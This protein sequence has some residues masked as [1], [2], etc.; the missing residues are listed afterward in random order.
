M[1]AKLIAR[2]FERARATGVDLLVLVA[3]A[4][5]CNAKRGDNLAWPSLAVLAERV[6]LTVSGLC[7][8]LKRLEAIGDIKRNRSTGGRNRRSRYL[9]CLGNSELQDTVSTVQNSEPTDSV[10]DQDSD[11]KTVSH[12]KP[13][14]TGNGVRTGN[15]TVSVR[16][17]AINKNRTRKRES[18]ANASH[19]SETLSHSERKQTR[20]QPDRA[21]SDLR[22]KPF[23][24]WFAEEYEKRFGAPYAIHWGKDGKRIKE[25]PPAFDLP[26]LKDLA[27]RF[28][29]SDD[30]WIREKGGFTIGVF[31][32]QINKLAS[33]TNHDGNGSTKPPDVKDLGDGWLEVDG[34][35]ISRKDY[36][37]RW[38]NN[39]KVS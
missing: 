35:K 17:H 15:E 16:T 6:R 13:C 9:I 29:E 39:V 34:M 27:T 5:F 28:F 26:R 8:S 21:A 7:K 25:L 14:P 11:S 10:F 32:S 36:D 31:T 22:V 33:T 24:S 30:P 2:V 37:R 12:R 3:L 19:S 20:A 4:H 38:N 23:L 1:S 18:D